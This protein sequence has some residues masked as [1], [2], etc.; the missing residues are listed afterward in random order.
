MILLTLPSRC[1][2]GAKVIKNWLPFVFGPA[3]AMDKI[4]APVCFNSG[5]ISSSKTWLQYI[6]HNNK[7]IR[8]RWSSLNIKKVTKEK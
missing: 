7:A 3:F 5:F 4:P 1:E 8:I 6:V 2:A